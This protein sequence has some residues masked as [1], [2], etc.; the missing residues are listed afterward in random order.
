M[1][2]SPTSFRRVAFRFSCLLAGF[3]F[4][5][6]MVLAS[7]AEAQNYDRGMSSGS[8]GGGG[9]G[10]GSRGVGGAAVGIGIGIGTAVILNEAA[11]ARE[12][13]KKKKKAATPK[14]KKTKKK[15]TAKKP[16]K[17]KTT[18]KKPKNPKKPTKQ[19]KKPTRK[20]PAP[21]ATVPDFIAGEILL[22]FAPDTDDAGVNQFLTMF[23]AAIAD[24]ERASE[25]VPEAS[26]VHNHLGIAY[27]EVGRSADARRSFERAVHLDCDN[28]AAQSNLNALVAR[29][30][31]TTP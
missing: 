25:L 22:V 16:A 4:V 23:A 20:T 8:R 10:G 26:E 19:A 17:K 9:G 2:K 3:L 5:A 7:V 31:E 1:T 27:L 12:R 13:N 6:A 15:A 14:R 24:L 29:G 18:A 21:V 30:D 11:K 28:R